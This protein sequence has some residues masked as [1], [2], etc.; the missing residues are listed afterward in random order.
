MNNNLEQYAKNSFTDSELEF[1]ARGNN[2]VANAYRELL[3]F[4]KI[5]NSPVIQDGWVMVPKYPTEH[6]I[7]C[8]FESEPDKY[9]S[10][11]DEWKAYK[12]MSGCQQAAHRAKL[13]WAAMIAATPNPEK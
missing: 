4:R 1:M 7:V 3:E 10:E 2:P 9:F 6:M 5:A 8:G 12:G 13:C 11:K